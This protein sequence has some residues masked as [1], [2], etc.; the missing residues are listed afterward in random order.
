MK[1]AIRCA[2]VFDVTF[3]GHGGDPIKAWL[4]IPHELGGQ[5]TVIVEYTGY[6]GGRGNPLD[7]LVGAAPAIR[8]S[9]WIPAAKAAP[10]E[11]P[12]RTTSGDGGQP[13]SPGFL[14]RGIGGP[15]SYYFTRLFIDSVRAVD[16]AGGIRTLTAYVSLPQERAKEED[17]RS[18]L[19]ISPRVSWRHCP[20]SRSSPTPVVP[21]RSPLAFRM[22]NLPSTAEST[23]TRSNRSSTRSR[24]STL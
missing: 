24:T 17:S 11:A 4:L 8:T 10:G 23:M 6:G 22:P 14:T 9:S 20:T 3:A 16:A 18:Q 12:T 5:E 2:E 13:S 19:R 7:W 1:S 21:P 15:R